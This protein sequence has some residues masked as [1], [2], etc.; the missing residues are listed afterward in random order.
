MN[1]AVGVAFKS[2]IQ[3]AL[4]E[5]LSRGWMEVF[6]KGQKFCLPYLCL[7]AE[8]PRTLAHPFSVSRV[9]FAVIIAGRKMFREV[10]PRI[11]Q[12]VLGFR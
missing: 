10:L 9:S 3:A 4:G 5:L 11:F 8:L 1:R 6:T 7:Q 2:P 12:A